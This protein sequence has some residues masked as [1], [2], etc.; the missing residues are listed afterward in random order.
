MLN[1][2]TLTLV[3][4]LAPLLFL[5]TNCKDEPTP[6]VIEQPQDTTS[7]NFVVTRIDTLGFLFSFAHGVDIVNENNIWVAGMFTE[8]DT[9]GTILYKKN[10][11]HWDGEQWTL[12]SIPMYGYNNTG[13]SP[14]EL[15]AVKVFSD[16][17]IF[18]VTKHDNSVAWWNGTKWTSNYVNDATVSPIF[19]AR[20]LDEIYFVA[21][22]GRAT[23][24]NGQTFTK[25][26]T[27]LTNPPLT[28]VWGDE[29]A[30]YAVGYGSSPTEGSETVFL[31]GNKTDWRVVN[32]YDVNERETAPPFPNQYVGP[33]YSVFRANSR[34]KL[35]FLGG[36][37]TWSQLY[38]VESLSPFRAKVFF[39]FPATETFSPLTSRGTLDND[40]YLPNSLNGMFY[41]Y[42]G[43]SWFKYEPT[44]PDFYAYQFFIKG[45]IWAAVGRLRNGVVS[46]ALVVIGKH[47]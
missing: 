27:G 12:M 8:K 11:A 47:E 41:H 35:W 24:Y 30:V 44:V 36:K 45:N 23:Y 7:H 33:M 28:D 10:L 3:S 4:V 15:G 18:V 6:P 13:P 32:R 22:E 21:R 34:S 42:N 25:I 43:R 37:Y 39:D 2:L 16:S 9:D 31:T 1:K 26:N 29:N 14:E 17:L 40:L 38:E 19:W 20:S 5:Q 46:T